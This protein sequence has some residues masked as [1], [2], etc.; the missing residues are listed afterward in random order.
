MLPW[1]P[2]WAPEHPKT[3]S[4]GSHPKMQEAIWEST[5]LTGQPTAVAKHNPTIP[6]LKVWAPET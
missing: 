3:Q 4:L 6:S 2:A 5:G 1:P